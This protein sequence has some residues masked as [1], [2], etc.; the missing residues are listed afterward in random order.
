MQFPDIAATVIPVLIEFLSDN[1]E[2]AATDVMVFLREAIYLFESLRPLIIQRLLEVFQSIKSASVHRAA[3][4]ILGE[5][6]NSEEDIGATIEQIKISLGDVCY[7]FELFLDITLSG[8][9]LGLKLY[10]FTK[11]C[12]N[13]CAIIV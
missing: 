13:V 1:I 12:T 11:I 2:L 3:L 8:L 4:W 7:R 5:F 10:L 6:A 9:L